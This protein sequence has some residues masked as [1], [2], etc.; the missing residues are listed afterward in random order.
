MN[1]HLYK[2]PP[3]LLSI[4]SVLLFIIFNNSVICATNESLAL[5]YVEQKRYDEAIKS[6]NERIKADPDDVRAYKGLGF[7]YKKLGNSLLAE[8]NFLAAVR[9]APYDFLAKYDLARYYFVVGKLDKAMDNIEEL[10]SSNV[11]KDNAPLALQLKGYILIVENQ[12]VAA[13]KIFSLLSKECG[14]NCFTLTGLGHVYNSRGDYKLARKYFEDALRAEDA[15][16]DERVMAILGLGWVSANERKP[17]EAIRWYEKILKE[18]PF[19][20]FALLGIGEIYKRQNSYEKAIKWYKEALNINPDDSEIYANIGKLYGNKGSYKEA[21][22]WCKEAI[23]VGPD[24]FEG[25]DA[26]A[27]TY[28]D[29]GKYEKAL[30]LFKE[31]NKKD[32]HSSCPYEGLGLVYKKL[33]KSAEAEK[34]LLKVTKIEADRSFAYHD[35]ARYYFEIGKLDLAR[36]N[37]DK[38][39]SLAIDS[40]DK[41]KALQLKGFI[42][43]MQQDY[44]AAEKLFSRL[45]EEYGANCATLSGLGHIYNVRKNYKLARQYFDDA[46]KQSD[47]T[48][49]DKNRSVVML[50]LAWISA[51]EREYKKAIKWY[52]KILKEEPLNM[53]ALLGMGNAYNNLG[54]YVKAEKYF[55]RALEID[56]ENE[57]ALA[58]LG[59]TY[60]NKGDNQESEKLLTKSMQIN[61]STYSCPYE[62]LGILYF[63]QGK[64]K[65]AQ[66]NFKKAIEINPTIEYKKY[67]GLARIYIKQGKLKEAKELLNKSIQNYPY[68]NEAKELLKEIE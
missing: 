19:N 68:D 22:K 12:L 61:S 65:E 4:L 60:L 57:Y 54:D 36:K 47:K 39:F 7:V 34:N 52:K 29:M 8:E 49:A 14:V 31:A 64:T 28:S 10:L 23:R 13:E 40:I 6:L 67:N 51:N 37:I 41:Q 20:I 25:Y 27:R 58:G 42:L 32:Y 48:M 11:K 35:L 16:D 53:L 24:N 17:E 66:E 5:H 1:S 30:K 63:Q 9:I 3:I 2:L 18:E 55:N 50:G 44:F 38:A 59:M 33:G 43:I 26:L 21:L 62:G 15:R 45:I 46:L 56:K